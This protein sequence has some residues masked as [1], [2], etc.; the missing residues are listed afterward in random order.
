MQMCD[1]EANPVANLMRFHLLQ[2]EVVKVKSLMKSN[3]TSTSLNLHQKTSHMVQQP[4][5]K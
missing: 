2:L 1:V 4:R 5:F 3:M